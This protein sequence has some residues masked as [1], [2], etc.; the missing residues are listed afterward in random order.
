MKEVLAITGIVLGSIISFLNWM[1]LYQ[2]W[3]TKK[4]VSPVPIFGALLLGFGLAYFERTRY[5]AS[6]CVIADY[7]TLAMIA[8][9]PRLVREFWETS[10]LNLLQTFVG[11]TKYIEYTLKLYR[12]GIF[13]IEADVEP[14]QIANEY[15]AKISHFGFEGRWEDKDGVIQ[16]TEY[17]DNRM[18]RMENSGDKYLASETNYPEEKEYKYDML[19][20]IEFVLVK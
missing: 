12:K 14:P 3:R 13:V 17:N 2:S 8:S 6:L 1:T 10:R 5:Y 4:S 7:G 18:V 15:G 16:L 19:N 9:T 20:G 11:H